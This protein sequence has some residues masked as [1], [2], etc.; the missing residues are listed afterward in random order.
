MRN[1][2]NKERGDAYWLFIPK[3]KALRKLLEQLTK[4]LILCR[5]CYDNRPYYLVIIAYPF[6][7]CQIC[8]PIPLRF[9]LP[10]AEKAKC[11]L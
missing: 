9:P 4:C 2:N 1:S 8:K 6:G 11:I 10:H 5:V 3:E 7:A